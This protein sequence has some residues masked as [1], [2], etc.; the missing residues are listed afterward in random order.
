MMDLDKVPD[1][2]EAYSV[3]IGKTFNENEGPV[4]VKYCFILTEY[5]LALNEV[6]IFDRQKMVLINGNQRAIDM[7]RVLKRKLKNGKLKPKTF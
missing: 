2:E 5:I 6:A 1:T 7:P 4:L 3:P